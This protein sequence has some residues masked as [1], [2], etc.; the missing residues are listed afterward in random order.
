MKVKN[1][2]LENVKVDFHLKKRVFGQNGKV[3]PEKVCFCPKRESEIAQVRN[4][5]VTFGQISFFHSSF[6]AAMI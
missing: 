6:L 4:V 5:K 3:K 2:H 1:P